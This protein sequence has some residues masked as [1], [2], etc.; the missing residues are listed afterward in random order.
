MEE[1]LWEKADV[2]FKTELNSD[3]D[4]LLS[5]VII[6]CNLIFKIPKI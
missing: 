4:V 1:M 6:E 2:V 3:G 5:K